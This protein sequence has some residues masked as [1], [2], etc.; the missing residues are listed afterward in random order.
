M[1]K[2]IFLLLG[3]LMSLTNCVTKKKIKAVEQINQNLEKSVVNDSIFKIQSAVSKIEANQTFNEFESIVKA[4]NIQYDGDQDNTLKVTYNRHENGTELNV[5]GKGK[6]NYNEQSQQKYS[7]T[8]DDILIIYDS[9]KKDETFQNNVK[10][11]KLFVDN[12][13]SDTKKQKF[14][15][16]VWIYVSIIFLFLITLV[17]Y[18]LKK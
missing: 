13:K 18:K 3:T 9:L 4:L 1:Y 8:R 2:F 16:S 17:V 10:K 12:Y 5:V 7:L 6:A 15:F 14:D 11:S